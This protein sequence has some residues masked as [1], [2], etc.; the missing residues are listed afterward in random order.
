MNLSLHLLFEK[1]TKKKKFDSLSNKNKNKTNKKKKLSR[2]NGERMVIVISNDNECILTDPKMME[3]YTLTAEPTSNLRAHW[4]FRS[5]GKAQ[6]YYIGTLL[7]SKSYNEIEW[8]EM[9]KK[10]KTDKWIRITTNNN[11]TPSQ[12]LK[13]FKSTK[14]NK[15]FHNNSNKRIIRRNNNNYND[16][17]NQNK[18]YSQST[19]NLPK[20]APKNKNNNNQKQINDPAIMDI[21]NSFHSSSQ[22]DQYKHN[23]RRFNQRQPKFQT[24]HKPTPNNQYYAEYYPKFRKI[25]FFFFS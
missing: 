14:R 21:G 16:N 24:Q 18:M 1:Q 17:N 5:Q 10:R 25:F 6:R 15:N 9:R 4:D 20:Y 19:G 11:I 13:Q 12:Y 2:W 3:E 7:K 23:Q 8:S 22:L